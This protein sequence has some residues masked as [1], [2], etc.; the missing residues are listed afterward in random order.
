MGF[1]FDNSVAEAG[2]EVAVRL[3]ATGDC[4]DDQV[5]SLAPAA[6]GS[7]TDAH[8]RAML[9]SIS[10]L[11]EAGTARADATQSTQAAVRAA[12]TGSC[13]CTLVLEATGLESLEFSVRSLSS[14]FHGSSHHEPPHNARPEHTR[15]NPR[16]LN[17]CRKKASP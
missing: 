10:I 12:A 16:P 9:G 3:C 5:P 4:R 13:E 17:R 7:V 2:V 6:V 1:S 11:Q 8:G 15:P 14:L